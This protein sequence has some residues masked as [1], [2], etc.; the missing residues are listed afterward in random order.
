MMALPRVSPGSGVLAAA[1]QVCA[2]TRAE[3]IMQ[4]RRWGFWVAFAGVNALLLL[5][6]VPSA[7][8]LSH[9]PPTSPYVQQHYTPQ[10]LVTISEWSAVR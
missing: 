7:V 9:L 3:I 1:G 8:Y 10:D 2:T 4:W 6:T 5:I